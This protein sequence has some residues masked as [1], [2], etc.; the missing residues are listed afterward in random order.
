MAYI[1]LDLGSSYT[2]AAWLEEGRVLWETRVRVPAAINAPPR[3]EID[4]EV[5]YRHVMAVLRPMMAEAAAEGILLSTQMHGFVLTDA[6]FQPLTPYVSWQDGLGQACLAQIRTLLDEADVRPSG[7]PLKGNLAL[8]ALLARCMQGFSLPRG[9]LF[10]TLGGYIIARLTGRH[11]CHVTNAAPTGLC[12]VQGGCWNEALLQKTGLNMLRMPELVL[13]MTPVA[14]YRGVPVY[15]DLGDQQV[16]AFGA[17]LEEEHS[18]HVNVG[19]AGLLGAVCRGFLL[20]G[21]ESRPYLQSGC[22]LRTVSGLMGGRQVEAMRQ[23]LSGTKAEV[24]RMM[25]EAPIPAVQA[26]YRQ[27]ADEYAQAAER[28]RVEVRSLRYSGG[29]AAKNPALR[30]CIEKRF[31]LPVGEKMAVYD[32]WQGM[33]RLIEGLPS[34]NRAKENFNGSLSG[35]ACIAGARRRNATH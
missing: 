9:A 26:L 21:C 4:A 29:C 33:L 27:M 20:N 10:H 34:N 25:T 22:Y 32:I 12:D 24:W 6:R 19:T 2:K 3:Y 16:C 23:T 17:R 13:A 11:V 30:A 7:V 35:N 15:P 18:L 1:G 31:A 28:M 5:Y 14:A 8:C